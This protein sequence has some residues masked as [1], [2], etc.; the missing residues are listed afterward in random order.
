[1]EGKPDTTGGM[2]GVE[3][4]M[5]V[6]RA[7]SHTL[8]FP[9]LQGR[10]TSTL[11]GT[12]IVVAEVSF[13]PCSPAAAP[14]EP[15]IPIMGVKVDVYSIY[16]ETRSSDNQGACDRHYA[17]WDADQDNAKRRANEIYEG[18][19]STEAVVVIGNSPTGI[20]V[21]YRLDGEN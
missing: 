11:R 3:I 9:Y 19:D 1:M 16:K 7:P 15:L 8:L 10:L 5:P 13:W 18:R 14:K 20:E 2:V 17:G 21:L 12:T 6:I 4:S